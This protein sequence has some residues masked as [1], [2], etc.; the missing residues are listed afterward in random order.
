MVRRKQLR[1]TRWL[2]GM[3]S[4]R[5]RAGLCFML[6]CAGVGVPPG[7]GV[8]TTTSFPHALTNE[9]GETILL[10][11]VEEIVEDNELSDDDKREALRDL[12][13]EDEKLI[14]ALLMD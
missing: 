7:C 6:A 5:S 10:E 4:P 9:D 12:G 14:D 8:P 13:L 1:A 2:K 11:D 3:A